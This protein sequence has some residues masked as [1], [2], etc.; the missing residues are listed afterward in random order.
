MRTEVSAKFR[1][2]GIRRMVAAAGFEL[3]RIWTDPD[4]RHALSLATAI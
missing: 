1:P 2:D 3:T 4:D